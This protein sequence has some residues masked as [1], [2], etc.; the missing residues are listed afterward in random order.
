MKKT[1]A[2]LCTA[3][4]LGSSMSMLAGCN[5]P[6]AA[7]E[8][9]KIM[10]VSLNPE[11]EFVLD[12][13]NKVLS[14]NALNEEGNLIISADAFANVKGMEADVAAK[15]FVQVADETGFL[16]EGNVSAG[17]NE[18]EISLSGDTSKAKA[19]FDEVKAEVE[20]YLSKENITA[21][22]NQAAAIT[23]AQLK[24][25][26]EECA[27]Y[28]DAAKLQYAELVETLQ[29]SREETAG[30]YSQEL[31]NAYYEA[32]AFA[33]EQAEMEVLKS[34]LSSMQ[35]LAFDVL[36]TTYTGAVDVI[37]SVRLNY[38]VNED[39]IYQT[40]LANFREK[41]VEFL[42]YKNYVASLPEEEVTEAQTVRLAQI[43]T[44]LDNME[45]ALLN[46]GEQA[47]AALD[48]AKAAVQTAYE[49]ITAKL[50]EWSVKAN[51]YVAE[52]SAKQTETITAFTTE[53]ETQYAEAKTKAESAWQ[54][55]Q[56]KLENGYQED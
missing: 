53:F 29:K 37:E 7:A 47:N 55:M 8:E 41:K 22:L 45:T 23:E 39:S 13:E 42:N 27:P 19:L 4:L 14:V 12:G 38:L 15:L 40:A 3:V 2:F 31:K 49:Q 44:A 5:N 52:I 48:S 21:T 36:Y 33:L 32:K 24:A 35:K 28:V 17:D 20:G 6:P 34:K 46:A 30:M 43:S 26:V 16:I 56:E 51:D 9:K 18:I 25:L 10:N 54:D 1:M 50:N 11:V